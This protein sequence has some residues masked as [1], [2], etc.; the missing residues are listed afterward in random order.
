MRICFNFAFLILLP[1]VTSVA[2]AGPVISQCQNPSLS[3][4]AP[5]SAVVPAE[6]PVDVKADTMRYADKARSVFT[7]DVEVSRP[8]Q[9][10]RAD[11]VIYNDPTGQVSA[12][13]NVLLKDSQMIMK[14]DTAE[15]WLFKDEGTMQNVQYFLQENHARGQARTVYRKGQVLT[16]LDGATYTTCPAGSHAWVLQSEHVRL[17]HVEEVGQA[18]H[19]VLRVG[20]IPIFYSPYMSFP[21]SDKR[22]SGFLTPAYGSTDETG[23][24]I[25]APYYWNISP[26]KDATFSP[27]YMS[28]RGLML[29]GEFRYLASHYSGKIDGGY[30]AHD[31]L[32]QKGRILNPFYQQSRKHFSWQ[33]RGAWA[34]GWQMSVDYNYISDN[35]YLQDF[36]SSLSLTS[37]T[38]VNR[39]LDIRYATDNWHISGR[40]QGYQTLVNVTKPYQRLPQLQFGGAWSSQTT[41][42]H[43]A[44]NAEY[45][46]FDHAS[47]I[48]GQ[49]LDIA[50]ALSWPLTSV[51]GFLTPRIA[52][53]QTQYRLRANGNTVDDKTLSRT[54]PIISL[55]SGVFFER[56]LHFARTPYLQT[57]EPRAFYLYVPFRN[58][59]A[60]PLFDTGLRTFNMNQL[61]SYDRFSGVDRIGD[62]NQVSLSLTSR[63]INQVTGRESLRLTLGQ[64][65]YFSDRR[66]TLNGGVPETTRHSDMIASLVAHMTQQWSAQSEIQWDPTGIRNH[67]S[68]VSVRY[69]GQKGQVLN[70]SHR[71]RRNSIEQV[72]LSARMPLGQHWHMVG[73]WYHSIKDHRTLEALAGIEYDSCCW[74]TRFVIRNFVN[75]AQSQQRNL[76]YFIQIELKGLGH[77][78]QDIDT[79]LNKSV[80]GYHH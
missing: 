45:V 26:D 54:V 2:H 71:Y 75:T 44:L 57:L 60:I 14:S 36:A 77:F 27:R 33:H 30:L 76:A 48:A 5:S 63:I 38:H 8:G 31:Q 56:N 35:A 72:D 39:L 25:T 37:T 42:L 12:Q 20:E 13:G 21:L 10:L 50:P 47:R 9:Q 79:L 28:N 52:I 7:G 58:Q 74:A 6:Q 17:D 15:W 43:Y 67:L 40:L 11:K 68:A 61:F 78:G 41:G 69:R 24:D 53:H 70:L 66:V 19:V 73:R 16:K 3:F 46:D 62:A 80:Q 32:R 4:L 64:R 1:A 51:A 49:R 18:R 55:D 29:N 23:L 22:K 59:N 65:R 34:P